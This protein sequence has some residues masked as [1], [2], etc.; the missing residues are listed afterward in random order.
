MANRP[1]EK[2]FLFGERNEQKLREREDG[3]SPRSRHDRRWRDERT[4]GYRSP[5]LRGGAVPIRG[6]VL[7]KAQREIHP[8]LPMVTTGFLHMGRF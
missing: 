6:T 7:C 8:A 4:A 1:A 3:L 2:F 5:A